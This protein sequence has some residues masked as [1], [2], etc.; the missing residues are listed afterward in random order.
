MIFIQ[1]IIPLDITLI[2]TE[3]PNG[4]YFIENK[5]T[6][7]CIDIQNQVMADG[8]QIHQWG[9]HG[10][11][12]QKWEIEHYGDGY[13]SIKSCNTSSTPFYYLT[14]QNNTTTEGAK[15]VLQGSI[16]TGSQWKITSTASGGY[17]IMAKTG[18]ANNRVLAVEWVIGDNTAN[19]LDMEQKNYQDNNSYLDEW[20]FKPYSAVVF[21]GVTNS[22]HDHITCLNAIADD[23]IDRGWENLTVRSGAISAYTCKFDLLSTNIFTSRSHG[24][25]IRYSDSGNVASTGILLNDSASEQVVFFSHPW[26]N[27]SSG[28]MNISSGDDYSQ[29][30]VA[31]FI[32]CETAAGE[33]NAR[34]LPSRI[35]EYGACASIGF[36]KSILCNAANTWTTN[37]Y[38][39]MLQG[40]T[41]QEAVDYAEDLADESSGLKSAVIGGDSTIVFP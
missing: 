20:V 24:Y 41:L 40:A 17:K 1:I 19:G 18:E 14:V 6:A 35:V 11:N 28:S 25:L 5:E 38:T 27:M 3:I 33:K 30:D 12:T 29:M 39:K 15:V 9:F 21:Y 10:G 26:S 31:L 34:N 7:K 36:S 32:G 2:V 16:S 4:I 23:M 37:F 22:G 13:Y 8:T